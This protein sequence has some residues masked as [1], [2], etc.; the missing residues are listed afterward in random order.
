ML[1]TMG[2][3]WKAPVSMCMVL[4]VLCPPQS[5]FRKRRRDAKAPALMVVRVQ[6][7]TLGGKG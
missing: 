7:A 3:V 2:T 6:L 5:R 1:P 4:I